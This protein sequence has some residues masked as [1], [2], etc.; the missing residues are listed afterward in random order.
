VLTLPTVGYFL[1][2]QSGVQ[3]L[4]VQKLSSK[5][6]AFLGAPVTLSHAEIDLFNNIILSDFCVQTPQ[7]DTILYTKRL[8]L[9]LNTF[10]I[11]SKYIEFRKVTLVKPEIHFY[12][13]STGIINFQF[14][15]NKLEARDKN[16][17][18][19][20]LVL[21]V[22]EINLQDADFT[23]KAF[24]YVPRTYGINFG[25]LHLKPFN[26]KITSFRVNQG[27]TMN[28]RNISA[29]DHSGFILKKLSARFKMDKHN[30]LFSNLNV[31]TPKS[32]IEANQV[33][34]SFETPKDFKT[35]VFGKKVNMDVDISPSDISTDDVAWFLPFL[36][37]HHLK[38]KVSGTFKGR[39][40]DLK[41]RNLE[42]IYGHHTRIKANLDINGLPDLAS[43][44]LHVDIKSLY[45]TP[46]DI[47][48]IRLP[49]N[50]NGRIVLPP[51]FENIQYI[52]Y[53]GKFTGF[54][55][56]FVAYGTFSSNLGDL[57]SD[58][59]LRPDTSNYFSFN[60]NLKAVQFDI[61]KFLDKTDLFG[62]IS[63]NAMVN[64]NAGTLKDPQ[65]RLDGTITSFE[66]NH[67]TY[68][69]IKIDGNLSNN[70]YDGS[71]SVNDPNV[72]FDFLGN[73]DL[74]QQIPKF[75]FKANVRSAKL[76][77]LNFE[78]KDTGAF[79]SFYATAD[80]EGNN[81]DNLNGEIKLWNSTLRRTG[82]EIQINDFLLFTKTVK[83]TNRIILRSDLADAEVWGT[84]QFKE[85]KN[86]FI[87]L[88][89]GFLPSVV[90]SQP[91]KGPSKNNFKFEVELKNTRQLTDFFIPGF[92]ISK[93]SK[94]TGHYDPAGNYL[95]FSLYI[96]LLQHNSKKWYNVDLNGKTL[97]HK[98]SLIAGS[99]DLK[100]NNQIDFKNFSLEAEI[101]HDSITTSIRWNNWDTVTYKGNLQL[102]ASFRPSPGKFFPFIKLNFKPSQFV[103]KDTVWTITSGEIAI[104]SSRIK[105]NKFLLTHVDQNLLVNGIISHEKDSAL[106]VEFNQ[107]DLNNLSTILNTKK[108]ALDGVI[109]GNVNVSNLY[110]NPI[111]H[112]SIAIDSFAV[113]HEPLGN[114]SINA[115]YN[116]MDKK[117]QVA[118][119]TE[120]GSARIIDAK[121]Y[122][123]T[124]ARDLNFNI[125][126]NKFK[127]NIIDPYLSH[128][129]SDIR[130]LA[131][132]SLQ[133]TGTLSD[134]QFNGSAKFQKCSFTVNYL[135]TRYNF[136]NT[137]DIKNNTFILKKAEVFDDQPKASKAIVNGTIE[138][139]KLKDI[140]TDIRINA[141]NFACLN[142]TE[143]DNNIYFGQGF[144]SGDVT[145]RTSPKGVIMDV[146]ATSSANT[147]L[148]IPLTNKISQ[149]SD[150]GFVRFVRKQPLVQPF[151]QYEIDN[152]NDTKKI[153]LSS[154]F[155]MNCVL[156][157]TPDAEVQIILDKKAGDILSGKG[158]G[159]LTMTFEGGNFTMD[160]KY[161]ID[162]GTYL[163]T[164]PN[165]FIN[166]LFVVEQG[167]TIVWDGSPFDAVIDV[168]ATYNLKASLYPAIIQDP[169]YS[170][171]IPVE[172]RLN[173]KDKLLSPTITYDIDLPNATPDA[174]TILQNATSTDET[175]S[176]QFLA[177]LFA[178]SFIYDPTAGGLAGA[179]NSLGLSAAG[180]SGV[181]FLSNQFSRMLSQFN[182]D[183][184]VGFNWRPGTPLTTSQAEMMFSAQI[185]NGR[186]L[187]NGNVDVLGN[188]TAV[189]NP[190]PNT[191]NQNKNTS[192]IVGEGNIE[193]KLNQNGKLRLKAFNRS[194]QQ[195]INYEMSPYTQ[196][197]GVYYKEN[198]NSFKDLMKNYFDKLFGKKEETPKPVE[199]PQEDNNS[200]NE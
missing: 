42:I 71:L 45:T 100:L 147:L 136:T 64:G 95:D 109:R 185:F 91:H 44:F 34:F 30:M 101:Q 41:G 165:A 194:N 90:A 6:S 166:K 8:E 32:E 112:A 107:V 143:N 193:F 22:R 191:S 117:V 171:P 139:R 128:I 79:V 50:K 36:K 80:F 23:L 12:I 28:V 163:F 113:N 190:Q 178:N 123:G 196:G 116:L 153:N 173:F 15:I 127:L 162:D 35:G 188:Q 16:P 17:S 88:T 200:Q 54:L 124:V 195:N 176:Q 66:V 186:L 3:N 49:R 18:T 14:I 63:L 25:N 40:S 137:V 24:H 177:L 53:K 150:A 134:P 144:A 105:I 76:Y 108:I 97:N 189:T 38:A 164:L 85:L 77:N 132:G 175:K 62:K 21:S 89:R 59:S 168:K 98:F 161:T 19:H 198:F 31:I 122:Y 129:F 43:S 155:Q 65:A 133:L 125:D 152:H 26:A 68:Q 81:I 5:I 197:V 183:V 92:Y 74:S 145:I 187:I 111:F 33:A 104:D 184:D 114:T 61:G 87:S 99:N 83:D 96:P 57:E 149:S 67:Y 86:S 29:I 52:T 110:E 142:T 120:R 158:S 1:I 4:I 115:Q 159:D 93:D 60:G 146:N 78:K 181:E 47:E 84:Y 199:E 160:G 131:T 192:N 9:K 140:Y 135:K 48:R 11:S 56:D 2:N 37:D 169:D 51:S 70:T 180:S 167:G 46:S 154:Q 72:N 94:L 13:D 157:M 179:S 20:P 118:F 10:S 138:Y 148:S 55:N 39:F 69:N 27:V 130:G 170:K 174:Q 151:D 119:F 73:V 121:G 106:S 182:K 156:H 82:K 103:L 102:A 126:L 7:H 75:N 141:K 172:C 58:L